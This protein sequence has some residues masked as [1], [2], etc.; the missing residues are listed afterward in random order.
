MSVLLEAKGL[1]FAYNGQGNLL[2]GIDFILSSGEIV[3]ITGDSGCGK[4][5]F[6]NCLAGI[7]PHIYGG[8]I[9]GKVYIGGADVSKMKLSEIARKLG[10]LFQNPDTQLFSGDVED[11]VVF[12]P[13]NLCR[14]W[15]EIDDNL[16]NALKA[17]G[18]NEK[19][20][21][22][23]KTLSGG[24][25]QLAALAATL[26]LNPDILLFDEAMSQLDKRGVSA[27]QSC[28]LGLKNRGKGI[29]M[30]EHDEERLVIAD[31]I[32]Y[33]AGGCLME[34]LI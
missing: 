27:V 13:E 28:A 14:T 8:D 32:L 22:N 19:R 5:T 16:N 18:I 29:I 3:G 20:N 12:G 6:L 33:L 15:S 17:T 24:E 30:V 21:A 26:S 1:S 31:R 34:R 25:A 10:V 9:S 23:P 7:I 4:T 11:D 2:N